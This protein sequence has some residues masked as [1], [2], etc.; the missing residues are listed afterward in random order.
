LRTLHHPCTDRCRS[1][2]ITR[3]AQVTRPGAADI[4]IVVDFPTYEDT[5]RD[6]FLQGQAGILARRTLEAYGINADDCYITSALNCRPAKDKKGALK[7]A[8]L[9]CRE[10]LVNELRDVG[11]TK[12]LSL[13]PIGFSA[14]RSAPDNYPITKVRGRW[15]NC[16]GMDVLATFSP[17]TLMGAFEYFRDFEWDVCKFA[18]TEPEPTPHLEMWVPETVAEAR[19]AFDYISGASFVSL[20]IESTGFSPY[21]D[22]L[23]AVGLG[24]LFE[25]S[26]DGV[27]IVFDRDLLGTRDVWEEFEYL[28][29]RDDQA[30]VM[31][32]AK[33]D[34][35]WMK[36]SL[37]AMDLEFVPRRIEDTMLLNYCLDERAMGQF[38]SH[39]LKNM[40]RVRCDA[41]DYDIEMGK[42]IKAWQVANDTQRDILRAKMRVYL[43]LDCYYTARL[44][45]QL[46]DEV[47]DESIDLMSLYSNLLMPGALAL[48]EIESHG[49]AIDRQFYIDSWRTIQERAAPILTRVR[50]ATGDPEF[51]P[52]SPQQVK[53]YFY[54][55]HE[56][57][58]LRTARRGKLQE[59]P[60]SKPVLK[61][62][63]KQYPEHAAVI[64][65]I[66][67][68]RNLVKTAG[69]YVKGMLERADDDDRIRGDFLQHGTST[70]RL[71]S[72]N[73]NLQ[74]IPETSHTKIEIR[75]G[76][77]AP[78]DFVLLNAD[79]SQ[80][81]LRLAAH[82]SHDENFCAV[83]IEGRDPHQ[84][85]AFAF[86]QKPEDEISPYERYMAKCVNFGVAYGRGAE[87]IALGPEME[88]VE[89]IG[90]QRW[91]V[92]QVK[93]FFTAYFEH[94]PEFLA[95]CE[96]QKRFAYR[97]QYVES[98]LGR[99]RRFPLILRSDAGAVGRQ[100][101]N[102][103]IQGTASDFT[104]SAL[105]RIHKRLTDLN[106]LVGKTV[107]FIVSTVH[108]SILVECHKK[109]V[110]KVSA[111]IN[112]EMER[113]PLDSPVPFICE[114]KVGTRWGDLHKIDKEEDV[115]IATASEE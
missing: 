16:F 48:C 97:H 11:P 40:A 1:C 50:E 15:H 100:A 5:V 104:F 95:W 14:L 89:E 60:T 94:F 106:D 88:Y 64:D 39:S 84:E 53:K 32:N 9:A 23:L 103:P 18:T 85:V 69:T 6:S 70:G 75:N 35:K 45:M 91:S 87:S 24:V 7:N 33:F 12:V 34:L 37:E 28:L 92:E 72:A 47:A 26:T 62:L 105:I 20:D 81:E 99:R 44:F 21:R 49:V 73:P 42:W 36:A 76:F 22:D 63:R 58:V 19:L 46:P 83:F 25:D 38:Q 59:G 67:E 8:M 109:F 93:E 108:D 31:H 113:V 112:E 54:E 27:S 111:I 4:A 3:P 2:P 13:G 41:P 30:T 66:L 80:L 101:V 43:S 102:T 90:G 98:P 78:P 68:Y 29:Q 52:N 65:D 110:R 56:L 114:V 74:N 77:V 79:Y 107:A 82:L 51:N 57:P 17:V 96:D 71:A 86:F 61:M 10:R 55:Y 115:A